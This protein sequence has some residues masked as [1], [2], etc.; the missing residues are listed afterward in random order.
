MGV[1]YK[2]DLDP[3]LILFCPLQC[4][5]RAE[6]KYFYMKTRGNIGEGIDSAS[7]LSKFCFLF[8]LWDDI[9]LNYSRQDPV[10]LIQRA[11]KD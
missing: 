10:R 2:I 6:N 5:V 11:P 4:Q 1:T 9:F 8:L 7:V 3:L